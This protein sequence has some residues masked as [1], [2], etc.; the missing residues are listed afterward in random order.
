MLHAV[1]DW[2]RW[3][4]E[5][6]LTGLRMGAGQP[7]WQRLLAAQHVLAE[8]TMAASEAGT[9]GIETAVA[10]DHAGVSS[11]H[12]VEAGPFSRLVRFRA[13]G[14]GPPT[15]L[16]APHSGYAGAVLSELAASLLQHG[17]VYFLDWLDARL[18]PKSRGRF[19]LDEQLAV[20]L[21][22]LVTIGSPAHLV[23]VS[24]SGPAALAAA[25]LAT[26][27]S[28]TL[29][30][31][32]SLVLLGAPVGPAERRSAIDWLAAGLDPGIVD[33]CLISV[34]PERYPGAGRRVYPGLFQLMVVLFADP[35]AYFGAQAGLWLELMAGAP[36]PCDR[37]HA[38]LHRLVDVPAELYAESVDN[39]VRRSPFDGSGFTLGSHAIPTGDLAGLPVL[40]VEAAKDEL[41]GAG[42]THAVQAL[43]GPGS[44]EL[45]VHDAA[46][47]ALFVGPL[48]ASAV[49]PPL[50]GFLQRQR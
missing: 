38:D 39:L 3:L 35:G 23:G 19:G 47:H 15:L 10:R 4:L 43:A 31:P 7:L 5:P 9:E 50:R 21:K 14:S 16:V 42:A 20:V 48:F 6:W 28:A 11:A 26:N 2:Q 33:T 25:A 12:T 36:G 18:V 24:Q 22:A 45:T 41:V 32:R 49:A 40:T 13:G 46:H 29:P 8:R 27:A 1:V 37:L 34:V 17:D 44:A 30:R